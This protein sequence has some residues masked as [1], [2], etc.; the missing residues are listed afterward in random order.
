MKR[1]ALISLVF[2]MF[3]CLQGYAQ[4]DSG[5]R[6]STAGR[7]IADSSKPAAPG[8][9]DTTAT[10]V[11]AVHPPVRQETKQESVK[12][13]D[14]VAQPGYSLYWLI[15][16]GLLGI[17]LG[18]L[19]YKLLGRT[20]K[21]N[22]ADDAAQRRHVQSSNQSDDGGFVNAWN[23]EQEVAK[24]E[25]LNKTLTDE[26][27]QLQR[28]KDELEQLLKSANAESGISA[29]SLTK[30]IVFYM[31]QPNMNGRFQEASKR[32][33][34]ADA[35]YAFHVPRD[36]QSSATFEFIAKDAYLN[37]AIGNEPSW[38]SIACDRTNQPSATTTRVKTESPG[39][40]S[41]KDGEWEITRKAKIT[42]L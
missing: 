39:I 11:I 18:A 10:Q 37:A 6:F 33:E 1:S 13:A 32:T 9:Q 5:Q 16:C 27:N 25:A 41:L 35:L 38:I 26:N 8:K 31:P 19:G 30:E 20:A 29:M 17:I 7:P 21:G 22:R 15:G 34:A 14:T 40:A 2:L 23:L 12:D 36:N 28:D 24:L 4:A 42:Y 3:L